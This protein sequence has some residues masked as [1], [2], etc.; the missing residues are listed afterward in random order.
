MKT[1]ASTLHISRWYSIEFYPPEINSSMSMSSSITYLTVFKILHTLVEVMEVNLL[2]CTCL[3][4]V[5]LFDS[6]LPLSFFPSLDPPDFYP[7]HLFFTSLSSCSVVSSS[8]FVSTSTSPPTSFKSVNCHYHFHAPLLLSTADLH[9]PVDIPLPAFS[10][11]SSCL[12]VTTKHRH[13]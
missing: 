12:F 3:D 1:S 13:D 10:G 7:P 5:Y 9:H 4:L 8:C 11:A 6:S 2:K